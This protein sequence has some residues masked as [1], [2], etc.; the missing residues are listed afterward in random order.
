MI[1]VGILGAG[2]MGNVHARHYRRMRD[3]EVFF[4]DPD[5]GQTETFIERHQVG[6]A[7]SA[8]DLIARCDVIDICL[9]TPLHPSLGLRAI[10]AGKAVFIEKPLAG[11]LEDGVRLVEAADRA[12]V[13]LMPGHV[14]R[15]FPEYAAGRRL[16]EKGAVGTPAAA[17][18]RRGGGT[19]KGNDGWFMDHSR[20]GGVLIDLAI[21]DFDW[22]RWTLGEVKHLYSRSVGAKTGQGPDY[23]LTT[24]T[25]ESGCVAHVESTW[26]DPGGGRATY[27]VCGNAGMIQYDSRN[28]QT[29]KTTHGSGKFINEAPL[30]GSDDPYYNELRGFIDAVV[31]HETPPVNGHDGLMALSI[32]LAARESALTDKV[33]APARQF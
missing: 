21:H 29:L 3:V 19:P 4:F 12:G 26:M 25:F 18:T 7:P 28:T 11:S 23:A 6:A 9:P 20:S 27:E 30:F 24:L 16:V 15:F 22:L 10:A 8:D 31:K 5:Q 13:T 14:V 2:G 17:R 33:V 32:A 1:T